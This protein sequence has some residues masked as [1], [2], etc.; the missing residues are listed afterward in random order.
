MT[1]L[2][3]IPGPSE[4][5]PTRRDAAATA[6]RR[7]SAGPVTA[8]LLDGDLRTVVVHGVE[9]VRRIYVAVRDLDWNTIEGAVE[10]SRLEKTAG[11]FRFVQTSRHTA[12]DIDLRIT[13]EAVGDPDGALSYRMQAT[14]LSAFAYAKIGICVHHPV[15]GF[16]GQSYVASTPGGSIRGEIPVA[17]G[18]QIH[19]PDGTDAPLWDPFSALD[20]THESGAIV[21]HRFTGNLWEIEDQRNWTDANYKSA[22]TPAHLGYHHEARKAQVW[23]QSVGV[24]CHGFPALARAA[25]RTPLELKVGAPV[26]ARMPSLGVE[27]TGRAADPEA[28]ARLNPGHVRVTLDTARRSD[29]TA[30]LDAAGDARLEIAILLRGEA[31]SAAASV[32]DLLEPL[33]NRVARLIV[34]H[35]DEEST[36]GTT[37]AAVRDALGAVPYPVITGTDY[38]FNQ[39]NRHRLPRGTADGVAWTINPQIHAFDDLSIMESLEAHADQVRTARTFLPE[40]SLHVSPVTLRPRFNAVAV[41]TDGR[42]EIPPDPRQ[43]S[44]LTGAWTLGSIAQL[45]T[46]G[47]ASV[48]YFEASGPKGVVH[49]DGRTSPA[50]HV[51][52]RA[53]ALEGREILAVH[54]AVPDVIAAIA[55]ATEEGILLLVANLGP[56]PIEILVE[57]RPVEM[58]GYGVMELKISQGG[59]R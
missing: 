16:A 56:E 30:A 20:L 17:I 6:D 5:V 21:R 28:V 40:G 37:I 24:T 39:L 2:D 57:G 42:A 33:E 35:A 49:D 52:D 31:A 11:G 41:T 22:S 23:R 10:S 32:V 38:Y 45:A 26:G 58:Q 36:S 59:R 51:L 15:R 14:A 34:L 3:E 48:T 1:D 25:R 18:P 12:G 50:F 9:I 46:A 19:L 27:V 8:V 13:V 4:H 43:H 54:G 53:S 7:V 44:P 47:V 29:A 55:V